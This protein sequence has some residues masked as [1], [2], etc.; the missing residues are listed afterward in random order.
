VF[1]LHKSQPHNQSGKRQSFIEFIV[2]NCS[3]GI[4]SVSHNAQLSPRQKRY[5]PTPKRHALSQPR[6]KLTAPT[7]RHP[8]WF[9]LSFSFSLFFFF[10][11][12]L[13]FLRLL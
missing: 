7:W 2:D 8:L 11:F 5:Q 12:S 3:V 1:I 13:F 4:Y 9:G 10:F 6:Q